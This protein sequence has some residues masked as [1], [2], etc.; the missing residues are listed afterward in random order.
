[1]D[2]GKHKLEKEI[3]SISKDRQSEKDRRKWCNNLEK[4]EQG[5]VVGDNI[6][7]RVKCVTGES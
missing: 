4:E 2:T 6:S 7:R 3:E 1:V 5:K